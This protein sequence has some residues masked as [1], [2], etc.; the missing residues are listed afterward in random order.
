MLSS[1]L[2]RME[3]GMRSIGFVFLVAM[4]FQVVEAQVP[5]VFKT[6]ERPA[7]SRLGELRNLNGYFPFTP[8]ASAGEWPER[9]ADIK[10]RI[11]VSQGLWPEPQKTELNAV[12]HNRLEMDDYTI[13]AVYFESIPGHYVTGSLYRPNSGS[14]PFPVVLCPHGHWPDARFY[15]ATEAKARQY[16]ADGA[17]RFESAARNH[18]QAR[19]VQLARMGCVAFFYDTTGN[20]DSVQLG[21]RPTKSEHLD[22]RE[23]WGFFGVQAELRLQ[24]MMGLQTWNSIRAIDFLLQQ[25]DIDSSRVGVTGASGGGT[26]SMIIAAI[27]ERITAAMPCVMVSTAMQGGCT[28]ENAPLM[29]IGQGNID[30]AAAIAPRPLGI[31][32]ADDWTRE[33][34]TKGYPQ[35]KQLYEMLGHRNRLT[36][37]FH[38]H[39]PHNYNHVNRTVMYSFFNRHFKLGFKEPVLEKDFKL[40]GKNELSVWN[41][42]HP[43]PTEISVGD[44]HEIQLLK[45]ATAENKRLMS[46]LVAGLEADP[47]SFQEAVGNGW[48][49]ILG[50]TIDQTG[51]VTFEALQTSDSNNVSITA[52]QLNH[53]EAAEQLPAVIVRQ[54]TQQSRGVVVW[55]S[56]NGKSG[57][58]NGDSL[59]DPVSKLV[60]KGFT[61]LSADL[62]GQGEFVTEGETAEAQRMWYQRGANETWKRFAGYTYGYNHCLFA[63]RTHD[64]LTMLKYAH[65]IA[66]DTDVYLMGQGKIAGPL[67]LAATSQAGTSVHKTVVDLKGFE[68]QSVDSVTDPMFV[69]GSV[70]YLDVAGLLSICA[71][72]AV[73][74]AN[75]N[76]TEIPAAVFKAARAED[77]LQFVDDVSVD[78]LFRSLKPIF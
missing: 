49:T 48:R 27:D 32:A 36:A 70:K 56:A 24:N 60:K 11:L 55:V 18:I 54:D 6:G 61:V 19:C 67:A 3:T 17:E 31:T 28:C 47:D 64:I 45:I 39:F 22:T 15:D 13:E 74:V 77:K 73:W 10:R 57:L 63:R 69:P 16:I 53:T 38:T 12:I 68:F 20:S 65:S 66:K 1:F 51:N 2:I 62:F 23:D 29:R 21:H 46:S 9:Q 25:P 33:L 30:I 34:Q 76:N 40:L 43:A 58:W 35:L 37:A 72:N 26:Q 14:G 41:A 5:L 75:L 8:V 4:A 44:S 50:R 42:Q 7:D 52:G 78:L 71:P 59:I